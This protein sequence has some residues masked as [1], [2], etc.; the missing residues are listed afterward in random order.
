MS[1]PV[2]YKR[3]FRST[4]EQQR[5]FN[6]Q[7]ISELHGEVDSIQTRLKPSSNNGMPS[8]PL[9]S[10]KM[11]SWLTKKFDIFKKERFLH[12]I[13][14]NSLFFPSH[15]LIAHP[16]WFSSICIVT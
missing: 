6:E 5:H 13:R 1:K 4:D 2:F 16:V 14:H 11:L 12:V 10:G 15:E 9:S 3:D 7:P 8:L